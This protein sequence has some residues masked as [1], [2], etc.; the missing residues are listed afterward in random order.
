M[1]RHSLSII[2]E[3]LHA[4]SVYVA[5]LTFLV[6]CLLL[7]RARVRRHHAAGVDAT[8]QLHGGAALPRDAA[9]EYPDLPAP[10]TILAPHRCTSFPLNL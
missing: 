7:G 10:G 3:R 9:V 8:Q 4:S 1:L 6:D 2:S 5:D